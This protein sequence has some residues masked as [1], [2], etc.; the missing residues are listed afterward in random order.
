MMS[1]LYFVLLILSS[2]AVIRFCLELVYGDMI[3]EP[4]NTAVVN[5]IL[6][7]IVVIA[8]TFRFLMNKLSEMRHPTTYTN[9]SLFIIITTTFFHFL[10]YIIV[11]TVHF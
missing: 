11:P 8:L 5:V 7:L 3:V 10:Y 2:Y 9:R 6:L 4:W 1:I